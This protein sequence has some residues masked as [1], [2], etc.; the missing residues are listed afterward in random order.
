MSIPSLIPTPEWDLVEG[1]VIMQTMGWNWFSYGLYSDTN[2][3]DSWK[4]AVLA[5]NSGASDA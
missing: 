2:K 5:P 4:T 1:V 3:W